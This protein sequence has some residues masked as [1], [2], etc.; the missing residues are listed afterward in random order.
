M[1]G[2]RMAAFTGLAGKRELQL[3]S[4]SPQGLPYL[5]VL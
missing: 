4:S 2:F 3:G 1:N 5:V